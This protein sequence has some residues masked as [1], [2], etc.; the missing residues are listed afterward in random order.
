M[1]R[2]HSCS[3]IRCKRIVQS[4]SW[5]VFFLRLGLNYGI[6]S[7][8]NTYR[9]DKEYKRSVIHSSFFIMDTITQKQRDTF[10][11]PNRCQKRVGDWQC[12]RPCTRNINGTWSSKCIECKEMINRSHQKRNDRIVIQND[13]SSEDENDTSEE[14]VDVP[15]CKECGNPTR[16]RKRGPGYVKFCDDCSEINSKVYKTI[17]DCRLKRKRCNIEEHERLKAERIVIISKIEHLVDVELHNV[18]KAIQHANDAIV[19][20][21][22]AKQ[23]LVNLL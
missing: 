1:N 9:I 16:P 22:E 19:A 5:Q 10:G 2:V 4:E 18:D 14:G 3:V 8:L 6:Q 21:D 11:P 7:E 15:S 12:K 20:Y 13:S 23:A 17:Y